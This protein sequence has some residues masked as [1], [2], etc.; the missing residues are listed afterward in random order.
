[1]TEKKILNMS[2]KEYNYKYYIKNKEKIYENRKRKVE[3][4]YCKKVLSYE[5]LFLH[6][7]TVKHKT[8]EELYKLKN[9]DLKHDQN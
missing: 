8:N 7:K 2:V 1:M 4:I 5:S 6:N 3:C 9:P